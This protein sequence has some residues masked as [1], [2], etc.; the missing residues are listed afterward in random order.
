MSQK[1]RYMNIFR[2]HGGIIPTD[3][4]PSFKNAETEKSFSAVIDKVN[5][6]YAPFMA[7][8]VDTLDDNTP[9]TRV[10]SDIELY[11]TGS[12][13][14]VTEHRL[15]GSKATDTNIF[16]PELAEGVADAKAAL[17]KLAKK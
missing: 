9:A 14:S 10:V 2:S 4:I 1:D 17:G 15:L 5:Q 16:A 7:V 11:M 13:D 6:D 3:E 12:L 8:E